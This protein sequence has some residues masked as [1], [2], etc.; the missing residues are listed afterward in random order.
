MS[1]SP[2][3]RE[4][5]LDWWIFQGLADRLAQSRR[6]QDRLQKVGDGFARQPSYL[7]ATGNVVVLTS[8]MDTTT[9]KLRSRSSIRGPKLSLNLREDVSKMLIEG[10]G[11]LLLEDFRPP[12]TLRVDGDRTGGMSERT[13]STPSQRPGMPALRLARSPSQERRDRAG[14][15]LFGMGRGWGP[16]K[17]LIEWKDLMWYDFAIEQTRFEGGVELKHF[18]GAELQRVVRAKESVD[19]DVG[20]GRSTFLTCGVLIVDFRDHDGTDGP[21]R[22]RRMG[23][24]SAGRLWRFQASDG[25][26]LEDSAEG[27]SLIADRVIY[28]KERSLMAV[29]GSPRRKARIVIQKPGKFPQ[30]ISAERFFYNLATRSVE[31]AAPVVR[32]R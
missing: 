30:D 13:V 19:L 25:V 11:S 32:R 14:A 18:S 29:Y 22:A 6:E 17:T 21:R 27:L 4:A 9:G 24:L 8:E 12:P 23:R 26:T 31:A 10:A 16:S 3:D 5:S 2:S 20:P 7:L 15:G 1:H 28:E